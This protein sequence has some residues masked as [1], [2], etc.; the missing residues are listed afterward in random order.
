MIGQLAA[1]PEGNEITAA[2]RFL[3]TLSFKDVIIASDAI[4]TQKE[5]CRA[6]IDGDGDYFLTVKDNQPVLKADIALA[7][8][9]ISHLCRM[10]AAA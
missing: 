6:L 1:A 4:F 2:L 7:F 9:S 8:G 5:I 3:K 10:V